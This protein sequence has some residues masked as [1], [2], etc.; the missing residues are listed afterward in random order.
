MLDR[1]MPRHLMHLCCVFLLLFAQQ[2]A[3]THAVSHTH[4]RA[5][6]RELAQQRVDVKHGS[7][8]SG[9]ATLCAFDAAFGQ[10]LGAAPCGTYA[11]ASAPAANAAPAHAAYAAAHQDFLA[12]LSRGPP[13]S[14]VS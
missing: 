6:A 8:S 10:V 2:A 12:P 5:P 9:V 7:Q 1:Y 14:L 13:A 4:G 11:A 3:L